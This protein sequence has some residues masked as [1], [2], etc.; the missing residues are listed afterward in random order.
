MV[1]KHMLSTTIFKNIILCKLLVLLK[2]ILNVWYRMEAC[3]STAIFMII[4]AAV[5]YKVSCNY[6]NKLR[7]VSQQVKPNK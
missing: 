6:G 3:Y 1:L 5:K 4:K 7:Q 2:N